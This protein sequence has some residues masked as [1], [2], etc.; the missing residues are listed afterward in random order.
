M[1]NAR[2]A[3][4]LI[5]EAMV[6]ERTAKELR[7]AARLAVMAGHSVPAGRAGELAELMVREGSVTVKDAARE[8][9]VSK[10][11]VYNWIRKNPGV[12]TSDGKGRWSYSLRH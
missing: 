2:G 8:M 6:F 5:K 10:M 1:L 11:A 12:F 7:R 3:E 9:K 4:R